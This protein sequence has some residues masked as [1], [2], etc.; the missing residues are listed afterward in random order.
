MIHVPRTLAERKRSDRRLVVFTL[1]VMLA[2]ALPAQ[3]QRLPVPQGVRDASIVA[4]AEAEGAS[5]Y[6]K[7]GRQVAPRC[8]EGHE[9]GPAESGDF[10][11][12]GTL[13]GSRAL[14][15]GHTGKIW[16]RPAHASAKMPPLEVR[17]RNL[18]TL[19]DT[20]HFTTATVA[21][22]GGPNQ[23]ALKERREYFFPSGFSVP[24]AGRWLV[25]ATSGDN[26]GCFIVTA[27]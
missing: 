16:W 19:R 5:F 10:T 23:V 24:T 20:M 21:W 7:R 12:G 15:A 18:S 13:G 11:I 14:R 27:I 6:A 2:A 3:A 8:I 17:G 25:V 9:I 26:W 4:R 22:P 1:G